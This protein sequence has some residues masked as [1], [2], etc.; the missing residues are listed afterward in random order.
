MSKFTVKV[1]MDNQEIATDELQNIV[2]T[3]TAVHK[4]VNEIADLNERKAS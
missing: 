1:F 3:N 4:I 2:I